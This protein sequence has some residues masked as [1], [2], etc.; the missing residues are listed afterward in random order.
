[1]MSATI[2]RGIAVQARTIAALIVREMHTRFGRDNIGYLWIFVEPSLLT[3]GV[4]SVHHLFGIHLPPGMQPAPFYIAGYTGYMLFRGLINRAGTTVEANGTLLFHRQVTLVDLILARALLEAAAL[5]TSSVALLGVCAYF[6]EGV[7]IAKPL[8]FLGGWLLN[9][10]FVSS[11]S[12]IVLTLC[13][14]FHVVERVIHPL[15]YLTLPISG[16]FTSFETVP[17]A[18]RSL[19][20][21]VPLAQIQEIIREGMFANFTSLYTRPLYVVAWC[22]ALSMIGLAGLRVARRWVVLE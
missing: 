13:V 1:M 14:R 20:T 17:P 6:S 22:V 12:M 15:T 19:L 11:L 5:I 8:E 9:V 10:W 2:S 3:I 4:T 7:M 21:W 18:F 16:A